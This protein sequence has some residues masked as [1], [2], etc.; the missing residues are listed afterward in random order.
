MSVLAELTAQIRATADRVGPSVVTI[1]RDGRGAGVIVADGTVVTN[2]HNLRGGETTVTF[3]DGRREVAAVKATDRDGDLA[4]LAVATGGLA[5]VE[6]S[7]VE[8]STGDAVLGV[9]RAW[10]SVRVTVGFVSATG[11]A[12]RGPNGALVEGAFEHTAPLGRGSS[13]G[14]VVDT[15]GRLLGLNTHRL[16]GG[17]YLALPASAELRQRV[18]ALAQGVS[19]SRLRLGV[20]LAPAAVGRRMRAAVGLEPRDG[21]LIRGVDPDGPGARAGL[22]AGDLIV[23]AGGRDIAGPDDLQAAL[24]DHDPA[25]ALAVGVLRGA[26]ELML[27]VSFEPAA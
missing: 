15:D 13:G 3:P 5:A 26:E 27:A 4:A 19:P 11:Q 1:G 21:L 25:T 14:P 12:F 18:D 20:V 8:P 9:G 23:R 7:A 17:F 24:G 6:W 16:G 22:A 10:D 2:A